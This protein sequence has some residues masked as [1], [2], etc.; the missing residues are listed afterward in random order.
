[1]LTRRF[2]DIHYFFDISCGLAVISDFVSHMKIVWKNEGCCDFHVFKGEKTNDLEMFGRML[3]TLS[4]DV[5]S[6]LC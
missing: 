2:V 6:D 4:D 5:G 1:V 3:K